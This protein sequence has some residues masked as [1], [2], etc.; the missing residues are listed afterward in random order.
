MWAE[1]VKVGLEQH[2][3]GD[4]KAIQY[5]TAGFRTDA[6]L[7]DHVMYRM[8]ILA[9]LRS[10]LKQAAIGVMITASHNQEK[11]NGVKLV[12]PKGEMLEQSW[13][14]LATKLANAKD[15]ELDIVLD[16]IAQSQGIDHA[17][18]SSVFVGRDTRESSPRL[19][20]AILDGIK[21]V[22]GAVIDAGIVS[23]PQ[24][25]YLVVCQNTHG[26]YGEA[27][28]KGYYSKIS[29]AF[30]A[31]RG[32]NPVNGRYSPKLMFDGANG[33]GAQKMKEFLTFLGDSIQMEIVNDGT[34]PGDVLNG[35]CG[36]D[37]VKVQQTSPKGLEKTRGERCVSVDGDA[38]R[39]MY[40]YNDK[41]SG[42]FAMLDGDRIA[43][44][45]AEF[46][47]E[48]L[49]QA[50]N[51]PVACVPT[52]VKHLHH[53]AQD[54]D[55][56]VYFEANGHGTIV[57]SDAAQAKIR[58]T[59]ASSNSIQA[60]KLAHL[61]DVIN[62]TVGDA[63]S[64]MLLVESIL[65]AKGWSIEDWRKAYQDLPNRQMK[66]RVADRN[67][68]STTDA[69]R[70]VVTPKGLQDEIDALVKKFPQGR[71]FVRPSG[72][73][74]VVRVYSES[75]TQDNA[76]QLA[77]EVGLKVHALAGGVGEPTPKPK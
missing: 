54:F 24:L 69:E 30:K 41:E 16:E 40:F 76:D 67:V 5:G 52:G 71:S 73:E 65:H 13:E 42:Q 45:V 77:Y 23:T 56:G 50:K 34:Q 1:A 12:D 51:V 60:Q 43:T 26:Q 46:L 10:K 61:V 53:K 27:S 58:D 37:F 62:Q 21:A 11:D 49:D 57:F 35:D 36:A 44:L 17:L 14:A 15:D 39:V 31:F 18:P 33:V 2:A 47:K 75:D 28:A 55:I 9:V 38:D 29:Q 25:H 63:I 22:E 74:D 3:K 68:I 48:L 64:D 20:Q 4:L 66:V 7:L 32:S 8:G 72:T 19:A 70:Q 6:K 59:A